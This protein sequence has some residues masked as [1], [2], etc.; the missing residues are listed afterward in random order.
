[1]TTHFSILA[2]ESHGPRS[3]V[4]FSL[5][6]S[7]MTEATEYANTHTKQ[8]GCTLEGICRQYLEDDIKELVDPGGLEEGTVLAHRSG[9]EAL[10]WHKLL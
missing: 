8:Y 5:K 7:H 6:E 2:A 3:L 4:G 10:H 9:E 1:M